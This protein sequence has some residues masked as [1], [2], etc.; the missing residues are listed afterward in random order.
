MAHLAGGGIGCVGQ[1]VE[2]EGDAVAI[3]RADGIVVHVAAA[4]CRRVRA[5]AGAV[6]VLR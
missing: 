3:A 2:I 1:I 6:E 5:V 4:D